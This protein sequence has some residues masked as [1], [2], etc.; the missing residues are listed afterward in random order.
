M[1][2]YGAVFLPCAGYRIFTSTLN[3][4]LYGY[5]W[6]TANYGEDQAYFLYFDSNKIEMTYEKIFRRNGLSVRLVQDVE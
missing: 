6:S 4:G 1:E 5:Y 3:H 2:S